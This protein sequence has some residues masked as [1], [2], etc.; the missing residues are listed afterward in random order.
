MHRHIHY[1][2][3]SGDYNI[4]WERGKT[5]ISKLRTLLARKGTDGVESENLHTKNVIANSSQLPKFYR[6]Q[7]VKRSIS[8][9]E[10]FVP[11]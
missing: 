7:R 9:L 5:H 10:Y 1:L 8:K 3:V 11:R 2:F 4:A 6:F